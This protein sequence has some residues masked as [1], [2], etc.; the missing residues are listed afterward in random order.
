[1]AAWLRVVWL[2]VVWLRVVWL[3]VVWY[4]VVWLNCGEASRKYGQATNAARAMGR[5]QDPLN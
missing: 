2:R 3:R 4:P 1:L 5:S